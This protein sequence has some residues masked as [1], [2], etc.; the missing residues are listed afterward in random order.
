MK[1]WKSIYLAFS[2]VFL[3]ITAWGQQKVAGKLL[4]AEQTQLS[5]E[6]LIELENDSKSQDVLITVAEK[7]KQFSLL[8][9]SSATSGKIKIEIFAPNGDAQG[10]FSVGTQLISVKTESV[11]GNIRKSLRE[12]QAGDWR[13]KI[14]PTNA[15]GTIR[16]TTELIQ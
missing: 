11:S 9:N 3:A 10:N 14:T 6:R 7:T 4:P 12:P 5:M 16:I 2:I 15:K 13:I 8:I 1:K